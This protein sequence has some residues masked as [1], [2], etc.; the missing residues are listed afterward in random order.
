MGCERV[1]LSRPGKRRL[2]S[3]PA[4]RWSGEKVDES[5][6]R[7]R[8]VNRQSANGRQKISM[9]DSALHLKSIGL[10]VYCQYH[11]MILK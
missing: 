9:R 8:P 10:S 3:R 5:V 1:S 2:V 4:Q 6:Y 11:Y 7:T